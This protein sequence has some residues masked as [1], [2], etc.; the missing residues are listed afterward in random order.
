MK[1]IISLFY[2]QVIKNPFKIVA[3][4][5]NGVYTYEEINNYSNQLAHFLISQGIN[6]GDF[7]ALV[8]KH[9]INLVITLLAILK[10]GCGFVPI[11]PATPIGR[12]N[13][14]LA[15]C[16]A[17]L[18]ISNVQLP[19]NLQQVIPTIE[20]FSMYDNSPPIIEIKE[21]DICYCIFT[22]GST[23]KPKGVLIEHLSLA[24][25]IYGL[26][27][28]IFL[29]KPS[30]MAAYTSISFDIFIVE[31]I[32]PLI[33]GIKIFLI[34][35]PI[36]NNP[37]LFAKFLMK[38]KIESIQITPSK[39]LQVT[40][41]IPKLFFED[42]KLML[43]GGE[44]L[45]DSFLNNLN[46]PMETKLFNVYGPTETTVWVTYKEINRH[47]KI[48]A[49]KPLPGN[50]ISIIK[51][52]SHVNKGEIGEVCITGKNVGRGYLNSVSSKSNPFVLINENRSYLTGDNGFIND[53]GD[54]VILGRS[55]DQIKINGYRIELDE[56]RNCILTHSAIIN[57]AVLFV[58][59][60]Q[61]SKGIIS[62][63]QR[64][65]AI[66]LSDLR[67][68]LQDKLPDY[69]VPYRIIPINDIPIN[70]NGKI[71]KQKLLNLL[72]DSSD[73]NVN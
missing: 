11:D 72:K 63:I 66:D 8:L 10:S 27:K 33:L 71:D 23:G 62:F 3:E 9:D 22:S 44:K 13:E 47:K 30:S 46:T 50:F 43:I 4:D 45:H 70:I 32:L 24:N 28:S 14:I 52:N 29:T 57:C 31:T 38:N 19:I 55:D 40:H 60:D 67:R 64:K 16:K 53:E 69:M 58:N 15:D 2:E 56:I 49:G 26:E 1:N 61:H 34:P 18:I 41:S 7:I 51:D 37:R 42:L 17:K 54:L 12:M 59:K 48:T 68:F 25:L 39:L 6:R 36:K 65:H 73:S 20:G 5:T 35:Y 21:D